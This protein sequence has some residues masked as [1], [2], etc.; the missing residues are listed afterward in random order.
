MILGGYILLSVKILQSADLYKPILTSN[1]ANSIQAH[2]CFS[3]GETS[4]IECFG[5]EP[6][7]PD[8]VSF[9]TSPLNE[10][11]N[12][13]VDQFADQTCNRPSTFWLVKVFGTPSET[14]SGIATSVTARHPIAPSIPKVRSGVHLGVRSG[15]RS[16]VLIGAKAEVSLQ[17][18]KTEPTS[19]VMW[20]QEHTDPTSPALIPPTPDLLT[21]PTAS[22]PVSQPLSQQASPPQALP[23][24]PLHTDLSP[25][26]LFRGSG[27]GRQ[28]TC[29]QQRS[30]SVSRVSQAQPFTDF[31]ATLVNLTPA[32]PGVDRNPL[33][34]IPPD[35]LPNYRPQEESITPDPSNYDRRATVDVNGR[36]V[37]N[38]LLVVLHETVGSADSALNMFQTYHAN[39]EDQVSYHAIIR[40]DGTV[41]Y[42][43]PIEMR[44]FGAG[45]SAF[46]AA[47]G[48]IETVQTNPKLASSVNNFAYHIS[49]ESPSDGFNYDYTHSGY[50]DAQYRSLAWLVAQ[51]PVPEERI[52]THEAVDRSNSRIDPRSFDRARFLS[53]LRA[54]MGEKPPGT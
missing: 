48:T 53:L 11:K 28:T 37:N 34:P 20:Q 23:A 29:L 17:A 22:Q 40:R 19:Q 27:S 30:V 36:F 49:L 16:A 33:L 47:D 6:T 41:V 38:E 4:A 43:V 15:V 45:N 39:D 35:W 2:H 8:F 26:D 14:R 52:T 5:S 10:L 18:I 25:M 42:I 12:R 32:L 21:S 31:S 50:S 54:Y 24:S 13:Q 51:L 7:H 44:A 1:P 46:V 3:R 9:P